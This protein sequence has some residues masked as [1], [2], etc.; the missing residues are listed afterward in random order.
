[1]REDSLSGTV[2]CG[3]DIL[4][5]FFN[6]L[7]HIVNHYVLSHRFLLLSTNNVYK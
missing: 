6:L 7:F 4:P 5:F 3:L 2:D 1:M